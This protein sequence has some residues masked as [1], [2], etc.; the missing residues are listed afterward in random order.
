[1]VS[2]FAI[3]YNG[4][5]E[6]KSGLFSWSLNQGLYFG[7]ST[8]E[9]TKSVRVVTYNVLSSHLCD[10]NHFT[11]CDK[12]ALNHWK[13]LERLKIKLEPFVEDKAII[14]LQEVSDTWAGPLI[15]WFGQHG[16]QF[17]RSRYGNPFNNYMGVG[18][19]Y[20]HSTYVLS[21]P[22]PKSLS[23]VSSR[24]PARYE[25]ID[26]DVFRIAD[27]KSWPRAPP[28]IPSLF[29]SLSTT[30]ESVLSWWRW[31]LGR[32]I[33]KKETEEWEHS[34][35][36]NNTMVS[37]KV[38]PRKGG[39][40]LAVSTYH[41]PCAFYAP[42]VMV[43]HAALA[44]QHAISFAEG[45]PLILAGDW[46]FKPQDAPYQ[47]LTTG[48][49]DAA[50]PDL[51]RYHLRPH[52]PWTVGLGLS[53]LRSAYVVAEGSEPDFTNFAQIKDE[54]VFAETLDYIFISEHFGVENVTDLPSKADGIPSIPGPLPT[55]A[56]PSDHLL[57]A[58]RLHIL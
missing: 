50:H 35:K 47:L 45:G 30:I 39:P 16:Y 34:K 57:L 6:K 18:I 23:N 36:R 55:T 58:A 21:L 8:Q 44:A 37:I 26:A 19:A 1:M 43:V 27:E 42:K 51:P 48:T 52:D 56:E 22:L 13:R 4:N 31:L 5:K 53:P 33:Q 46:N 40:N 41:M 2:T 54:P 49:L 38:R 20:C 28:E 15:A 12:T 14:C 3:F 11:H 7:K 24:S 10:P 25:P 29:S 32:N 9:M 17:I